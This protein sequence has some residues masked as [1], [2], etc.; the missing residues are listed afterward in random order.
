MRTVRRILKPAGTISLIWRAEGMARV[1]AALEVGFGD[2][3]VLP[4]YPRPDAPA[5]RILVRATK[6]SRAGASL[7]PGILL[8]DAAGGVP[9]GVQAVL[10]G[11]AVLPLART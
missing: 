3:R 1:L 10:N 7:M 8:N 2:I 4:V 9:D 11:D 6:S 5:V